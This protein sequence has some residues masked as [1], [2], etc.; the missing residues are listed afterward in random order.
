M[1]SLVNSKILPYSL[2][3]NGQQS[4]LLIDS[5]I[6]W[7]TNQIGLFR[8]Q[9]VRLKVTYIVILFA[10]LC[11]NIFGYRW[12]VNASPVISKGP[13]KNK[14]LAIE[15][16]LKLNEVFRWR[17][18]RLL[19]TPNNKDQSGTNPINLNRVKLP[20]IIPIYSFNW[21][22]FFISYCHKF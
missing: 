14:H 16:E 11:G 19:L 5:L 22:F 4:P 1:R 2:P 13:S 9:L 7:I 10:R 8:H 21:G 17:G 18:F 3:V 12:T 15:I 20:A 6:N